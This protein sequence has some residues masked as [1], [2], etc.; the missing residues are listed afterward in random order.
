MSLAHTPFL[1]SCF[2]F[3]YFLSS[4]FLFSFKGSSNKKIKVSDLIF[5]RMNMDLPILDILELR[6]R[7]A[8][9]WGN[10]RSTVVARSLRRKS[11]SMHRDISRWRLQ[12]VVVLQTMILRHP[13]EAQEIRDR[14][15]DEEEFSE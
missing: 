9:S 13:E 11:N 3:F 14:E 10:L 6:D 2:V 15:L 12:G 1:L 8:S 4:L 7:G 5:N